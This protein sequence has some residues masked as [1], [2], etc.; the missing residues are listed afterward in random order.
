MNV[1]DILLKII[2]KHL[3][4]NAEIITL[5]SAIY[6][7]KNVTTYSNNVVTQSSPIS[8]DIPS[9]IMLNNTTSYITISNN[10]Y[11]EWLV[12]NNIATPTS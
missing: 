10:S 8:V 2:D 1:T 12:Q 4:S 11:S 6:D 3:L 9:S 5:I 7:A